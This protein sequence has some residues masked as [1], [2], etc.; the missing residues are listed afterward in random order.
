M[1]SIRDHLILMQKKV[2]DMMVRGAIEW[3]EL[4]G[5]LK[6]KGTKMDKLC[7]AIYE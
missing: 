2:N 5:V 3:N 1:R 7:F 6:G 4:L